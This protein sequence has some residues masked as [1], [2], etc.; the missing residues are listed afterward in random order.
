MS[1]KKLTTEEKV[2]KSKQY[3]EDMKKL[4]DKLSDMKAAKKKLDEEIAAEQKWQ[5]KQNMR[6]LGEKVVM[7]IGGNFKQ[8]QYEEMLEY[9]FMLDEVVEYVSAEKEKLKWIENISDDISA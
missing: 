4:R 8:E 2:L 1:N 9:I 6:S 7:L 3:E 5:Q